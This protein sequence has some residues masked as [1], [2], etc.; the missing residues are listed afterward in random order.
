[1]AKI[2][3]ITAREIL[4]SRG[5][6]T[7]EATVILDNNI[8]GVASV[9]SGASTGS[10][11]A[12]ELRDKTKRYGGKGVLKAV[13]NVNTVIND[14]L[15]GMNIYSQRE[16]DKKMIELDGTPNK[17]KLGANAILAV[18]LACARASANDV[19]MPLYK[20]IRKVYDLKENGWRMPVATMNIINGGRHADNNLTIQE[21]MIVPIHKEM[22]ERVRMGSQIFHSLASIL[23][24]KGYNTA[25]GDEGGFAPDL[26]N[27]EQALKL[28]M[29]AIKVA[30]FVAG[31]NVFLAMDIAASEFYRN[32]NYY[33]INQKQTSSANKIGRLLSE[34]IKKYPIISIE[35]ALSEDDWENWSELTRNLG[36][37]IIL[38]GDDVF[39][40]NTARIKKG[41]DEGVCNAVLIKVNQI[42]T[43]SE[44]IDAIYLARKNKYQVSISHRSGET[45]DTFI[46]D[47]AVAVNA[48]FIK[49]GSMSRSERVEKYNRLM[50]IE[51]EIKK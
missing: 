43:L 27:N 1:M 48:E 49:T 44:A 17:K 6:P 29:L 25:V 50:Q 13:K 30:G 4:D 21:F 18:S 3:K 9:P 28:L 23:R 15:N 45:A 14:G 16:I 19:N 39:V 47:L 24:E 35:D 12:V 37:K 38:V 41:I 5:N 51:S 11:E 31:K 2:K 20:Y 26:L 33:F 32:G 36:K 10:H 42:G 46:A 40:T 22:K 8:F 34:W 7:V